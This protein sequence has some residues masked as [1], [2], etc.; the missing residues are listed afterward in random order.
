MFSLLTLAVL[1]ALVAADVVERRRRRR[2]IEDVHVFECRVR[3]LGRA[4]AGWRLLRRRWSRRRWAWWDGDVL[5]IRRGPVLDRRVRFAARVPANLTPC[6]LRPFGEHGVAV[7]L[8]LSDREI[9]VAAPDWSRTQLVGPYLAAAVTH[10]PK[11][12]V[13]RRFH[14]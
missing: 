13:P 11:A 2:L 12:P 10:L 8:A 1:A 6:P 3:A 14:R 5:V 7:R 4:P 9:Q